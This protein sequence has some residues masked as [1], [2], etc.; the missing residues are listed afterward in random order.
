MNLPS[1]T[2][3]RNSLATS[4]CILFRVYV[5][6]LLTFVNHAYDSGCVRFWRI[7]EPAIPDAIAAIAA[8]PHIGHI[9]EFDPKAETLESYLERVDEYFIVNNVGK[10]A[11]DATQAQQTAAARQKSAALNSIIGRSTYAV[12]KDLTKPDKPN[13]KSY[14]ELC[15]L[16]KN[17]YQ[18]KTIQVAEAFRFHRCVQQEG[19][20]VTS[21]S[22]RLRGSADNC[23][24]GNFLGRALRDQFVCGIKSRDPAKASCRGQDI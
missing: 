17:H 19:E 7:S 23:G 6:Y 10:V 18:P 4:W 9:G 22:A 3:S 13:S 15:T 2:L 5:T 14:E 21:Y 24:F 16:L 8:M 20:S 12:L 1:Y 11:A